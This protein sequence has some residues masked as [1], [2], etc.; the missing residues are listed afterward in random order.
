VRRNGFAVDREE[1]QPGV[2]GIGA[3]IRDHAGTVVGAISA[4]AP[5]M[6]ATDPHLEEM[7]AEVVAAARA[8][9]AELGAPGPHGAGTEPSDTI[10]L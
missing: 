8:L 3:A 6:R 2:I 7:R 5:T 4:L 10:V 9:S 1:F